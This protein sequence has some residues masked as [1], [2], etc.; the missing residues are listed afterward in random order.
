MPCRE[1]PT[2]TCLTGQPSLW[3]ALRQDSCTLQGRCGWGPDAGRQP[4]R[5]R[6]TRWL[7]LS[8]WFPV[9]IPSLL[10]QVEERKDRAEREKH[11]EHCG[12]IHSYVH[13]FIQQHLLCG[14]ALWSHGRVRHSVSSQ[15]NDSPV[16]KPVTH[17]GHLQ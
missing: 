6:V 3:V 4:R 12:N 16:E 8:A 1:H 2:G 11:P 10:I 9:C 7:G 17:M 5:G 14:V 13:A 15:G